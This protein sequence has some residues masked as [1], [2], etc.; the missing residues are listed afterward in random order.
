MTDRKNPEFHIKTGRK[1]LKFNMN[2]E[3]QRKAHDF[4]SL[5]GKNQASFI[6]TLINQFLKENGITEPIYVSAEEAKELVN[7]QSAFPIQKSSLEEMVKKAVSSYLNNTETKIQEKKFMP[8]ITEAREK[9][10]VESI[11]LKHE[12]SINED[13][14]EDDEDSEEFSINKD[15]QGLLDAFF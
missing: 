11:V 3:E 8:Q 6:T 1:N 5:L 10:E 4:L 14:D 15:L 9:E 7:N 13:D 2:D 12:T